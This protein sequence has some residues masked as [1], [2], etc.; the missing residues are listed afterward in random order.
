M[1]DLMELTT[2]WV[3]IDECYPNDWNPNVQDDFMYERTKVS[4]LEYGW[5]DPIKVRDGEQGYEIVDGEH[6]WKAAKAILD[7]DLPE[8]KW[9]TKASAYR[10]RYKDTIPIISYGDVSIEQAQELTI[11]LNNLSGEADTIKLADL[12]VR[13]KDTQGLDRLVKV[14]PFQKDILESLIALKHYDPGEYQRGGDPVSGDEWIELVF[15]VPEG[16]LDAIED[17]IA[18]IGDI[19]ELKKGLSDEVRRGLILEKICALSAETPRENLE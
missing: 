13:L 10:K 11:V 19:L 15:K 12:V 16:A 9:K 7:G 5:R 1:T 8:G 18:R 2:Q 14:L 6:R 4:L 17:E 3:E